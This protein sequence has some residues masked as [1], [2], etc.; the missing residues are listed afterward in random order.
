[1]VAVWTGASAGWA[2]EPGAT[3]RAAALAADWLG[4][5][6][7]AS[8]LEIRGPLA[9]RVDELLGRSYPHA[10]ATYWREGARSAWLLSLPGKWGPVTAVFL[11]DDGRL[12]RVEI[13]HHREQRGRAVRNPGFLRQFEGAALRP[14]LRMDRRIEGLSGATISTDAVRNMARLALLLDAAARQ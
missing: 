14:D 4:R 8:T 9:R 5:A 13:L 12:C 2:V 6:S 1:L 11:V 3:N 10:T 7:P